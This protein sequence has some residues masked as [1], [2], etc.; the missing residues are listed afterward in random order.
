MPSAL[1]MSENGADYR[2][3]IDFRPDGLSSR[4]YHEVS[5]LTPIAAI[6]VFNRNARAPLWPPCQR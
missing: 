5:A 1:Q 6:G 4:A 3:L 2:A